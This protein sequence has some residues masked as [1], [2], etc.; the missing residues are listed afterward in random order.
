MLAAITYGS[1]ISTPKRRGV[2]GGGFGCALIFGYVIAGW[3]TVG[4]YFSTSVF[5]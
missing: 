4:M 1:E 2:F 5:A 3:M